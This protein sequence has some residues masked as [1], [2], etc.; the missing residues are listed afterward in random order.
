MEKSVSDTNVSAIMDTTP[1]NFISTRNKRLREE[2]LPEEFS[3]FRQEIKEMFS[4]FIS[5]Q[6]NELKIIKDIQITNNNIET[7]ITHLSQQN[8]EFRKKIEFLELQGRKDRE[9]IAILEDKI[10]DLQ[11]INRKSCIEIKNV[12]K[13]PQ[14]N[15]VD[16]V[17]M[18]TSLG[19]HLSIEMDSRDVKDIYRLPSKKAGITNSPIVVELNSTLLKTDLLKKAKSFNIKNTIKLQA[20]HLG[21]RSDAEVPVFI[22][23]QL[24]PKNAR[25]FF[26]ARD[27]AKT[28]QY[29]FCWTAF[30]RILVKKDEK[31]RTIVIR[32]EAQVHHLMQEA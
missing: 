29:K 16:L 2:N 4:S 10:E 17:N 9:Y 25:L 21:I 1:P 20:K 14:E 22:S 5:T 7:A 31:A 28:K 3:K 18:V 26:L 32:S 19:K 15:N 30:G 27:L 24:T 8:D 12:P 23:E 11:R 13:K 6:Q